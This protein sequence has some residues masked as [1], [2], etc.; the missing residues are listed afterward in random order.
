[1]EAGRETDV[2]RQARLRAEMR[3]QASREFLQHHELVGLRADE[4]RLR[5]R[6]AGIPF[7]TV[8]AAQ[9]IFSADLCPGRIT[10]VVE[11]G[12]VVSAEVGN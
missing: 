6:Q 7:R 1:M 12:V 8:D 10:V 2:M 3:L 5:V 11:D 4:A 9:P